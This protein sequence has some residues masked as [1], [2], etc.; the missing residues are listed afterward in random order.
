MLNVKKWKRAPNTPG[1]YAFQKGSAQLYIGKAVNLKKRVASYFR[2]NISG[3][4]RELLKEATKLDWIETASEIEAFLKE[5]ELIKKYR[6][7]YN[8]L[9][10]D[11]KNYFYVGITQ[12][13]FPRIFLTHQPN[14]YLS[15]GAKRNREKFHKVNSRLRSNS[16]FTGPFTSGNALKSVLRLLRRIFPYCTCKTSHRRPCLNTEI[17]RCPGYCCLQ[18]ELQHTNILKYV[19]VLSE[20]KKEYGTNI[21]NIIAVLCGKKKRIRTELRRS[22]NEAAKREDFEKAAKIRDQLNG[23]ENIF[24][25]R[26]F[27]E[28]EPPVGGSTSP[29]LLWP[30]VEKYIRSLLGIKKPISRVEGYDI[31]NI[32]GAEATGSMVVFI[33]GKPVKSEYR[34][35]KIKTVRGI[36]DVGMLREV[37]ARR[38]AHEEWQYPDLMLIDGG[39]PQFNAILSTLSNQSRIKRSR[40][41]SNAQHKIRDISGMNS[42]PIKGIK[43]AALAK[44]E[45]ELYT[46]GAGR[47]IRL[48]SLPENTANFLKRVRD[49]SHR[50]AKKYH[51][52]LREISFR[53]NAEKS[54]I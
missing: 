27:L 5:A 8:I 52:K 18:G 20:R 35:F 40:I 11:D 50:F 19:G 34:K 14:Q 37:V 47:P 10:R 22:M 45:E 16:N 44:R 54:E 2:K 36:S 24:S 13:Q 53:S 6:P 39:K 1:V 21:K 38:M 43:V 15:S 3:K 41:I 48:S 32:S 31:S 49:E 28:V 33:E 4:T 30:R 51:H 46:E 29:R 9:M 23:L 7:K 17:G 12:E 26:K 42:G 25:H